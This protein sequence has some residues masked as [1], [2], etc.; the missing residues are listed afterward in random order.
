MTANETQNT[1]RYPQKI[2]IIGRTNT[3]KTTKLRSL[4][5]T[6]SLPKALIVDT[7]LHPSYNDVPVIQ[8]HELVRWKPRNPS[9]KS[10]MR[11][12][13]NDIADGYQNTFDALN[14]KVFDTAIVLEDAT[15]FV[16]GGKGN[17]VALLNLLADSKQ[18][19]NDIYMMYHA[20]SLVPPDVYVMTNYIVLCKTNET[21]QGIKALH[22]MPY[23]TEI[24]QA[25]H[26]LKN[27]KDEYACRIIKF[28]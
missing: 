7:I 20:L 11:L 5:Q 9:Q 12:H 10:F 25:Y 13:A 2:L 16:L 4:L 21:K 8:H 27:E 24:L 1:P 17:K 19:N 26:E 3:G 22:K 23:S 28:E 14:T 15:K 18:K 6:Q